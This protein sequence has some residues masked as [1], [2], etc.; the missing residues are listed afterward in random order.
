MT[1]T[2]NWGHA[3]CMARF[4]VFGLGP[5]GA[6]MPVYENQYSLYRRW[7]PGEDGHLTHSSCNTSAGC[8]LHHSRLE[9]GL[10]DGHG[11]SYTA[12]LVHAKLASPQAGTSGHT[13][14]TL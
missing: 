13:A 10:L 4:S 8:S 3:R 1:S 7:G 11:C 6:A 12:F 5:C 2:M 9:R 14:A